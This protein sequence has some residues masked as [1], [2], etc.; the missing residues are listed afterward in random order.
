MMSVLERLGLGLRF[1]LGVHRVV[2]LP[3]LD[4]LIVLTVWIDVGDK[5]LATRVWIRARVE[6]RR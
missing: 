3:W 4:G 6:V 2:L 1:R 5:G